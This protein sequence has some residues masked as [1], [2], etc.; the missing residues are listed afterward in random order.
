MNKNLFFGLPFIFLLSINYGCAN[1][2]F[3]QIETFSDT[4]IQKNE[5][6]VRYKCNFDTVKTPF[7]LQTSTIII[8]DSM[9]GTKEF[10]IIFQS[11]K[12]DSVINYI[13]FADE[14]D[15]EIKYYSFSNDTLSFDIYYTTAEG[16]Y[17]L[18]KMYADK[19]NNLN[20]KQGI[21]KIVNGMMRPINSRI[22]F[23]IYIP[24]NYKFNKLI[25]KWD[26][27]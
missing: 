17:Y 13:S 20:F 16:W 15:L 4:V 14:Q 24:P 19:D 1:K 10:E 25:F 12:R 18:G 27:R 3:K 26:N 22:R 9:I 8:T 21:H 5:F 11:S 6:I 7:I 2:S 23:N